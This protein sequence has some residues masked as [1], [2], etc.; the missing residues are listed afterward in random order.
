MCRSVPAM[1]TTDAVINR[2][3]R[4]AQ[5]YQLAPTTMARLAGLGNNTLR[6]F[7]QDDWNPRVETL[8]ALEAII[9]ETFER[10]LPEGFE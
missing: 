5:F 7:W 8:R 6:D 9:P 10:I 1:S 3:R 4:Y 2:V